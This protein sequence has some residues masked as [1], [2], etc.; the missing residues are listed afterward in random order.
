MIRGLFASASGLIAAQDLQDV[1]ANNLA[2]LETAG[3]KKGRVVTESFSNM[4][5]TRLEQGERHPTGHLGP[6]V[7]ASHSHTVFQAGPIQHTENPFDFA[8]DGEG[9]FVL[10]TPAGLRYSRDGAFT[11]DE[12]GFLVN[13]SGYRVLDQNGEH[14][15]VDEQVRPEQ[16]LVAGFDN[17]QELTRE[18]NNL[19][20]AP[21]EAG[22]SEAGNGMVRRGYIERSNVNAVSEM[23]R[24]ISAVR[25][26]EAGQSAIQ[27]QDET[28]EKAVNHVGRT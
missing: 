17:P 28:L 16:L 3:F 6:G 20:V 8:I 27:A 24:M 15:Y 7:R 9:F 14:I 1:V 11:L 23:T 22:E 13:Q 21:P 4:Y 25:L 18:G 5:M 10:E 19:F 12:G 2:N 26:F